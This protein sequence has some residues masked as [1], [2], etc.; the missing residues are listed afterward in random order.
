MTGI[1]L[2]KRRLLRASGAKLEHS[3]NGGAYYRLSSD[4]IHLPSQD[5]FA[6]PSGYYATALHELGHWTA[7]PDRLD[8]DLRNPFG[9]EAYA[10]EELRAEI[11]SLI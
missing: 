4:T 7:H 10:R 8:R 9:S 3:Q 11:A 6:T 5:R 1:R 2:S